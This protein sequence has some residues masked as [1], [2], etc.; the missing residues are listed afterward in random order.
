MQRIGGKRKSYGLVDG[1]VK[2]ALSVSKGM[3]A[4]QFEQAKQS[5][6]AIMIE[7]QPNEMQARRCIL[8]CPHHVS[9]EAKG[10]PQKSASQ[11]E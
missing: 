7:A 6:G 11:F 5:G 9:S 3:G 4:E 10:V 8:F 1:V 2:S